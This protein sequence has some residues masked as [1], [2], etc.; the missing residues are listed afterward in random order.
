MG[1]IISINFDTR[2]T[3]EYVL[4]KSGLFG[5]KGDISA[6]LLRLFHGAALPPVET[7]VPALIAVVRVCNADLGG[8][9]DCYGERTRA[10][11]GLRR[12]GLSDYHGAIGEVFDAIIAATA[13]V[14]EERRNAQPLSEL[15]L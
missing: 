13:A 10:I 15:Y 5:S 12:V 1:E 7:L 3:P 8:A 14:A 11:E 4:A 2:G 9:L 6:T